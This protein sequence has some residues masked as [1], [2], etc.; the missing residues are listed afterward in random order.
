MDLFIQPTS[1]AEDLL[2]AK[3]ILSVHVIHRGYNMWS[4]IGLGS[5]LGVG[6]WKALRPNPKNASITSIHTNPSPLVQRILR[7]SAR[8]S[9]F[10]LVFGAAAVTGQMW[11]RGAI[12][13][14]DRSWRLLHNQTQNQTDHWSIA[15]AAI[16]AISA[17]SYAQRK[18]TSLAGLGLSTRTIVLGGTATGSAIAIISMLAVRALLQSGT[19]V[20]AMQ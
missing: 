16:G 7:Y 14:Q 1:A 9:L 11:G 17:Y 18:A 13:W 10:G 19:N 12:E 15:G 4:L 5:A 6:A 8:G 20:K 2:H 3:M